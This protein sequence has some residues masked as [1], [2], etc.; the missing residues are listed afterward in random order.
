MNWWRNMTLLT[1][2]EIFEKM[3]TIR[4]YLPFYSHPYDNRDWRIIDAE[5]EQRRD[6]SIDPYDLL[7]YKDLEALREWNTLFN[8]LQTNL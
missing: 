7:L 8:N 3:H 1:D 6:N 2:S 4:P 5:N